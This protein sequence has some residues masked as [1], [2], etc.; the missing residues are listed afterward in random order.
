MSEK[1]HLLTL[2][3]DDRVNLINFGDKQMTERLNF[4]DFSTLAAMAKGPVV[5]MERFRLDVRGLAISL[6]IK[7][8][9]TGHWVRYA[10]LWMRQEP[11]G[12]M[13]DP[14]TVQQVCHCCGFTGKPADWTINFE[15]GANHFYANVAQIIEPGTHVSVIQVTHNNPEEDKFGRTPGL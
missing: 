9:K 1:L 13:P 6:V 4:Q 3:D 2:L 11:R 14:V 7:Q 5:M 15:Q 10:K 8:E 12:H